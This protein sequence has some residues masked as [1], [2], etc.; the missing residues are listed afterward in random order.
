MT[1]TDPQP[2][3]LSPN[4]LQEAEKHLATLLAKKKQIDKTLFNIENNIYQ[5]EGQYLDDTAQFGNIIKGFEGYVSRQDRKRSRITSEDRIFSGSS[6]SFK[7]TEKSIKIPEQ[8]PIASSDS[9]E[10]VPQLKEKHVKQIS[11][12]IKKKKKRV[13][14]DED[15]I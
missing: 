3:A 10:Y 5:L 1:Q 11:H 7:N 8:K 15:S 12:S 14:S 9:E 13:H 4:T 2:T 6:V